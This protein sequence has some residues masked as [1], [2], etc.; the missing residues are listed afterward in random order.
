MGADAEGREVPKHSSHEEGLPGEGEGE[1]AEATKG[2]K[3]EAAS[4]STTSQAA[5]ARS[6]TSPIEPSST[7]AQTTSQQP[8]AEP[9]PTTSPTTRQKGGESAEQAEDLKKMIEDASKMLKTMI[10][11]NAGATQSSSTSAVP[12]YESIQRQLD[13]LKLKAMKVEKRAD[14]EDDE[15][16]VLLDS[17]STH[18][19]RP[20]RSEAERDGCK[21]VSVTLAGDEKRTPLHQ[22]PAGSII[23]GQK[24]EDEA[25][26]IIPFGKLIEVLNC[27]VKWTRSG[28]FLKHPTHGR[29]KTRLK[30]GCPEITDAGQAAKI[31]SE[32]EMKRVEELEA[33]TASLRDQLNAIRMM[34]VRDSDWRVL[35]AKYVVQ[36][37]AVDGLQ[38]LYKSS[39]FSDC[40]TRFV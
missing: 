39:I 35:L 19:L 3:G 13:E 38:A 16:G 33:R 7:T 22:T 27:T 31:I 1:S 6:L 34:E 14:K 17:G 25:Q 40:P 18:V 29:I 36:G 2:K 21:E 32:L 10:A 4:F 37:K 24:G 15:V 12:T 30:G 26:T 8:A 11:S 5:S 20:A 23:V 28:L 9:S